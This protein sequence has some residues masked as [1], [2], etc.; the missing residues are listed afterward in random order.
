M[1]TKIKT[2]AQAW[3]FLITMGGDFRI[4]TNKNGLKLYIC[5]LNRKLSGYFKY[6]ESRWDLSVPEDKNTCAGRPAYIHRDVMIEA[7]NGY[8]GSETGKT[9]VE[10]LNKHIEKMPGSIYVP[11]DDYLNFDE[12]LYDDERC[13]RWKLEFKG[14]VEDF[15]KLSVD[16]D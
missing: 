4:H 13:A 16:K 6:F 14:S 3:D 8:Q 10:C 1:K 7:A 15:K 9:L 11:I 5:V 2:D 12:Q